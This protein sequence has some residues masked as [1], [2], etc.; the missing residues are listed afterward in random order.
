MNVLANL[1]PKAV[2]YYFEQICNIPHGS[3]N[4]KLI[5]DY[6]ADFARARGLR[7]R[8][9]PSNNVIIWKDATPGYEN[10]PAVMIQGHMDMV[11][12]KDSDCTKDMQT[13]GLDLFI[14]GDWIG[15]R[16]TT[17]G[18][19]NGIAVAIALAVLDAEDIP[20]GPLECLF[21]VDEEV[22]MLGAQALDP[23]GLKAKY[24]LNLDSEEEGVLTVSCA[25]SIRMSC[26]FPVRREAFDG[27]VLRVTVTGLAGGHSG[28][29]IHMCRANANVLMG[30]ILTEI[31]KVT[32]LRLVEAA[33]GAK[34]NVIPRES[35]VTVAVKDAAAAKKA[36]EELLAALRNEYA[37]SDSGIC[38]VVESAAAQKL[39]MDEESTQKAACFLFCVPNGVQNM[40]ADVPGLVQTSLNLG[41]VYTAE[42]SL[43]CGLMLRSSVNSQNWEV[44]AKVASLCKALG[45][46]CNVGA[47]YGAWQY[48]PVSHLRDVMIESFRAIYGKEPKVSALHAGLECGVLAAKMP[49]LDCISFGPDLKDIHTPR[50]R[51]HIAST[52]RIWKLTLETLK[53]LK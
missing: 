53:R 10:S 42:D 20:H 52:E 12:E 26:T 45:G 30:R 23:E 11:C 13:E 14:D 48:Q 37:T 1:E 44:Q 6:V 50:E 4:T 5:S 24:M 39:P 43:G 15:A 16:G 2:F 28:E 22:G 31:G 21:T 34:E 33:G 3:H 32:Q 7:F 17:L 29:E 40:S 27:Q 35:A 18:S 25:G 46:T 36:V 9:D 38:L 47:A 19:D 41:R 49:G 51:I 8:Q